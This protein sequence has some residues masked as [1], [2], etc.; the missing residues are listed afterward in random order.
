[1]TKI[2]SV[3]INDRPLN[4]ENFVELCFDDAVSLLREEEQLVGER[5]Q[6]IESTSI[7]A[8]DSIDGRVSD[9]TVDHRSNFVVKK[10]V[11]LV[12]QMKE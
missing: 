6:L 5:A 2:F 8:F 4:D 10:R 12:G 7:V 1:M 11:C 3:R 9:A